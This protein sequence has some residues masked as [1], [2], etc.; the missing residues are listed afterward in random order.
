MG[1]ESAGSNLSPAARRYLYLPLFRL[2]FYVVFL[3]CLYARAEY[4]LSLNN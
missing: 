2:G 1:A 3:A 4:S